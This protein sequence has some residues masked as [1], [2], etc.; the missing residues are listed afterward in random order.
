MSLIILSK[1]ALTHCNFSVVLIYQLTTD[2]SSTFL[3][4]GGIRSQTPGCRGFWGEKEPIGGVINES[5]CLLFPWRAR[6]PQ[7]YLGVV[8]PYAASVRAATPPRRSR[9]QQK[10][11][12]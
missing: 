6:M 4:R 8:Q 7:E 10:K 1:L 11:T 3:T 9:N 5:L 12:S 2:L